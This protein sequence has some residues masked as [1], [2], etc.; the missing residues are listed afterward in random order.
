MESRDLNGLCVAEQF[1]ASEFREISTAFGCAQSLQHCK[2]E[3][4]QPEDDELL[5]S[6]G[7]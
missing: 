1:R 7:H 6:P 2:F 4:R 3:I 5:P